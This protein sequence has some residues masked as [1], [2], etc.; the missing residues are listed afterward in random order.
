MIETVDEAVGK[1]NRIT[2]KISSRRHLLTGTPKVT[3]APLVERVIAAKQGSAANLRVD[4]DATAIDATVGADEDR[5]EAVVGHLVQNALEATEFKGEILV[6]LRREDA[7]AVIEVIDDGPGMS[8]EFI[9]ND[10]F[11]PF[12]STKGKGFGI[13]AFQCRAYARE[14][15]G[16]LDV[17][18]VPGAGTT[19]RVILPES[20]NSP[21]MRTAETAPEA[22]Q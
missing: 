20:A 1:M 15:G 14:L 11:R 8:A 19:I 5:L 7:H 9:R 10:L 6:K 12:R 21:T 16:R 13:G 22:A 2:D 3:L 17:E 18:S 4:V